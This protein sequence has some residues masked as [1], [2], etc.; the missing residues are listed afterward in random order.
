MRAVVYDRYGPP[1]VQRLAEVERPVPKDD[2]VL[3]KIHAAEPAPD[4]VFDLLFVDIYADK[5]TKLLK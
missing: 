5:A 4:F 3:I 1:E 2:E